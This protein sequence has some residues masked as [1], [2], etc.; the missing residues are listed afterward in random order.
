MSEIGAGRWSPQWHSAYALGATRFALVVRRADACCVPILPDRADDVINLKP[1]YAAVAFDVGC[2]FRDDLR[3]NIKLSA[4]NHHPSLV[5][6][7]AASNIAAQ[8]ADLHRVR[9]RSRRRSAH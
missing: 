4:A 5:S 3:T 6:N 2:T 9:L 7:C 8:P 1:E